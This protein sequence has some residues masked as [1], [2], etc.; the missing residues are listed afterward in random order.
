MGLKCRIDRS[1]GQTRVFDEQGNPDLLFQ[2]ALSLTNGNT[3]EAL[4]IWATAYT[5]EFEEQTGNAPKTIGNVSKFYNTTKTLGSRLMPSEMY[6]VKLMMAA[7]GIETLSEFS[8]AL[9]KIFKEKGEI[10]F[11]P[12]LAVSSGL[13]LPEDLADLDISKISELINKI[14]GELT[15]GDISVAPDKSNYRNTNSKNLFGASEFVSDSQIGQELL[16][17]I[18][19]F[20]S[21]EEFYD[22][23][24]ELPYSDFVERFYSNETFANK[25]MDS[26]KGIK[27]IPLVE[28]KNGTLVPSVTSTES[29]VRNTILDNLSTLRI[30]ANVLYLK[31]IPVDI[32]NES[33]AEIGQILR[34]IEEEL[35]ESNIDLIGLRDV[36]TD[37]DTILGMLELTEA[38]VSR[39]SNENIK[40]FSDKY[41]TVFG[42]APENL[43]ERLPEQFS[44][45]TVVKM[46]SN[47][48]VKDL[49]EQ[50]GLI[51]IGEN[52]YHKVSK[53]DT[54]SDL[55]E[56]LFQQVREGNIQLPSELVLETNMDMKEG[57]LKDIEKFISTRKTGF[58]FHD[59][60]LS[61]YQV[62]FKHPGVEKTAEADMQALS[63]IS[64]N[65][66]YLRT[67]FVSDFYKY[68]LKE[69]LA[70]SS[71]YRNTLSK[72][73]ITDGDITLDG[74]TE[75]LENT[76][77]FTELVDYLKL[78]KDPS[79]KKFIPSGVKGEAL[80]KHMRENFPEL[81]N[82][83]RETFALSDNMV[84]TKPNLEDYVKIGGNM[85][86]KVHGDNTKNIY[87]R[88][89]S[90]ANSPYY[91]V[92]AKEYPYTQDQLEA[93]KTRDISF[94]T[95]LSAKDVAKRKSKSGV[96]STFVNKIV[97]RSKNILRKQEA[98]AGA[99]EQNLV[100]FLRQKG[101]PV[102]T[103]LKQMSETLESLGMESVDQMFEFSDM[104]I[105][106][107]PTIIIKD[108]S[109]T[110]VP[111]YTSKRIR[112][113]KQAFD[114]A[115]GIYNRVERYVK[116]KAGEMYK[117]GMVVR[118]GNTITKNIPVDLE[119]RILDA[120]ALDQEMLRI[121]KEE[122]ALEPEKI[123]G[124]YQFEMTRG[125]SED[126]LGDIGY[127]MLK[128][129]AGEVL[130]FEHNGTIYLDPNKL[131]N[132]A[133]I[134]ELIHVFQSVMDIKAQ[135]GDEQA[136]AIIAKRGELFQGLVDGWAK[137]HSGNTSIEGGPNFAIEVDDQNTYYSNALKAFNSLKDKNVKNIQGWIKA[138]TDT[139]KNGGEKNV[140]QEL[141]W[142]GLEAYLEN[143][144][145]ENNPK[146]G[147]I[148]SDVVEQYILANR[149]DIVEVKNEGEDTEN[150]ARYD[151]YSLDGGSNYREVLIT[152]P[153]AYKKLTEEEE[154]IFLGKTPADKSVVKDIMRK[155]AEYR[156]YNERI[157]ENN[158]FLHSHWGEVENVMAHIR[159]K[160]AF[161]DGEK[162]LIVNE[163]QS[164]WA[165]A[166]RRKGFFTEEVADKRE[167]LRL[168]VQGAKAE[169]R[170]KEEDL[171]AL[172]P[173]TKEETSELENEIKKL[174]AAQQNVR[175]NK[176]YEELEA[177][178]L[179]KKQKLSEYSYKKDILKNDIYELKYVGTTSVSMLEEDLYNFDKEN[180]SILAGVPNMPYKKTDQWVGLITRRVIQMA[181]Q[182]GYGGVAF[183]TGQQ[184]ADMYDLSQ[185][186][187]TIGY[188]EKV[189]GT[190]DVLVKGMDYDTLLEGNMTIEAI[191]E[192]LGKEIA[193]KI[194]SNEHGITREE[195]ED[196]VDKR[197][198]DEG[199]Y[200][201]EGVIE[202]ENLKVG[203]EGMIKFYDQIVPKVVQKEA[204]RFDKNAKLEIKDLYPEAEKTFGN[205][206][207]VSV[208]GTD[209]TR[210]LRSLEGL[211]KGSVADVSEVPVHMEHIAE[212]LTIGVEEERREFLLRNNIEKED[213]NKLDSMIE[214]EEDE[215]RKSDLLAVK[216][217]LKFYDEQ[218]TILSEEYKEEDIKLEYW[219]SENKRNSLDIQEQPYLKIT[220]KM[221][222]QLA[223][224]AIPMFSVLQKELGID[225]SSSAYA[226][227]PNESAVAYNKRLLQEVE[228]YIA[229]PA[230][231]E[232]LE[233][234][235]NSN[236]SL[237]ES[238][239]KF[240]ESLTSWLKSQIGLSD[241]EGSI[242]E[243]TMQEYVDALG[244]SVLK[245]DYMVDPMKSVSVVENDITNNAMI[246]D[247]QVEVLS[248]R[249]ETEEQEDFDKMDNCEL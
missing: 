97:E 245:D 190:Y 185:Q 236:P 98:P 45:L 182:E 75:G 196:D 181:A 147:N 43:T 238:I 225:L 70:N 66:M 85:Y 20:N 198:W 37:R 191:E 5:P 133:T 124:G 243:M 105:Q 106:P 58:D 134:H 68:M 128:T 161:K 102:V 33:L 174:Q 172:V 207:N 137:Y 120:E 2:E 24:R 130:G 148:P 80:E 83:Y 164:D 215:E 138:L 136:Q 19:N 9:N 108:N 100:E 188:N 160:D 95:G 76:E 217:V 177:D 233:A 51:K 216:R 11:S 96:L 26:F 86:R 152:N 92:D 21:Q 132:N 101:V 36:T 168:K 154:S 107:R 69:K 111:S 1:N 110:V 74:P 237:W 121:I 7:K 41:D 23:V 13:F 244:V 93:L 241:Y 183:V 153:A 114:A 112:T 91:T 139:Q 186:V 227:R 145:A 143:Y 151:A 221:R 167:T 206:R 78:K 166:G 239:V 47:E 157:Q 28:V 42:V 113:P 59:E 104:N 159:L 49:F 12:D 220:D 60:R 163:I 87:V 175:N 14:N 219:H 54:I 129:P 89:S 218:L 67:E 82:E 141:E 71:T 170:E 192:K 144:V 146:N 171:A 103:D 118:N 64:T 142:I 195:L 115:T 55:Y 222:E 176:E 27:K 234:L 242:S 77:Y 123:D 209:F 81:T 10:S 248:L 46:Y 94:G 208:K 8:A 204:Q 34:G 126:T 48:S 127:N 158:L 201:T 30:S 4:N 135:Q 116:E 165:Q 122:T 53:E 249:T 73:K 213:V 155:E 189:D 240:I 50:H 125:L 140:T 15:F 117:P 32:W 180:Q 40:A 57:V 61:L 187:R 214:K 22:K 63:T 228:A 150:R 223:G 38:M 156:S 99:F 193:K 184:A 35:V 194:K 179:N 230:M 72:I 119:T 197:V 18:N 178:I 211:S 231:A 205:I 149:L 173:L 246:L 62:I 199:S 31:S 232:R 25:V 212:V 169:V 52:L 56:Y 90:Q 29:T 203:G 109:V 131:S 39:P 17:M 84:I 16:K 235:K 229:A 6:E 200:V 3:Q 202:G 88:I 162:I 210:A 224:E 247:S 44:N 79:C 226:Q 65:D